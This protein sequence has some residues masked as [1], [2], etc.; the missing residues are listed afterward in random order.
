MIKYFFSLLL[1]L[2]FG[3]V[4][5]QFEKVLM[6]ENA[7]KPWVLWYWVKAAVSKEGIT[8]D[9]EAMKRNGIGGAFLVAVRDTTAGIPKD[10]QVRQLT[11]EFWAMVKFSMSEAKRIGLQMG[12][13]FSDG[14]ALGGGPW[15]TP[16]MSMQKVV[17]A[18]TV[19]AGNKKLN[20]KIPQT[21]T[22]KGYS[23]RIAV[24]AFPTPNGYTQSTYS[25]NPVITTESGENAD[26]LVHK[27]T[28]ESFKSNKPT[29]IQY[30]FKEPFLCRSISIA[31]NGNNYQAQK[32]LVQKSD[33]GV[34]FT[35]VE[36]LE[37]PRA[38][39]QD[40]DADF[41]YSIVPTT[42]KYFRFVFNREG[43]EPGSEDLDNAK[44]RPNLKI[45]N[46]TLSS[47]ARIDQYEGKA[48]YVWRQSPRTPNEKISN[49]WC[50]DP[51][52]MIDITKY[53][54]SNG[55]LS[56]NA[57]SGNWTIMHFAHTS[58]GHT[59]ATGGGGIGL[60]S[61]KFNADAVKMQYEH[62]YGEAVKQMG[63]ELAHD[64]L[65]FFYIDSW[66]CGSQNWS[67]QFR[68]EFIK[69]RQYDP[70]KYLP[71]MAGI[72]VKSI[73]ESERYLYDIRQTITELV[74]DKFFVTL[75]NIAH[76]NGYVFTAE[77][78]AP[79]MLGDGMLHYSKVDVPMSEFWYNS[80]THDKP[81]DIADAINAAHVYGKPIVQAEAF[82]TVRMLWNEH[83]GILK[84]VQDRNYAF[85]INRLVYHVFTHNPWVNKKPG[86]TLDGVGLLFQRD[87]TWWDNGGK[88]WVDYATNSQRW[89][90][91]GR[92][93]ADIAV[94]TGDDL[95][96]RSILPD[97]LVTTF[98][99]LMGKEKVVRE[100]TRLENKDQPMAEI[101]VGVFNAANSPLPHQWNDIL[102]GYQYDC[103]NPDALINLAKVENGEIVLPGGARYKILV[104][105][106][107]SQLLSNN[108][109]LDPKSALKIWDLINA[110]AKVVINTPWTA[111]TGLGNFK[112]DDIIVKNI[113]NKLSEGI[114]T[115]VADG[116]GNSVFVKNIG[117]GLVIKGAIEI[118]NLDVLGITRDIVITD[119]NIAANTDNEITYT[120]KSA[121]GTDIYFI[122]NQ[123]DKTKSATVSLRASNKY[124][125]LYD[126]VSNQYSNLPVT[127]KDN[128]T[129]ADIWLA[130]YQ[131]L[132]IIL[133]DTEMLTIKENIKLV[134]KTPVNGKWQVR[135]DKD[136]G[137][138]EK[139]VTSKQLTTWNMNTDSSIAYYSGT[140]S[141]T[142]TANFKKKANQ[143][144]VLN[145]SEIYNTATVRIN[146][147]DCGTLWTY[148][149]SLDVTK[150]IKSGKN[151]IEILVTNTWHNRLI[152][153]ENLPK[154]KRVTTTFAPFRLANRPLENAG[155]AGSVWLESF[156]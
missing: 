60:E 88:A 81:N 146:G 120:H 124:I 107:K 3:T 83:P 118:S 12:F 63:P 58:T 21:E 5:A 74:N 130:P 142:T 35:N 77:S 30:S 105:P 153:D 65:K 138:P 41:T 111:S 147:I 53:V 104:L 155:L 94:F 75:R 72:P 91:K 56:W 25:I 87:Q 132:F 86:M 97:R 98:P 39:W 37:A 80:P 152:G 109:L 71:A 108:H 29:W 113:Y 92:P 9:L 43:T 76:S 110:G 93:V 42:A 135:F 51:A 49:E 151:K 85:G 23:K 139:T 129:Q 100:R 82:T 117:S 22:Y 154:E 27:T 131:A 64:V 156:E 95:P 128:R 114:F 141:Y 133:T 78:V 106:A 54:N 7:E 33:D 69:R 46:L 102:N 116:N 143:K 36:Q 28:K 136:L 6:P 103:I 59:N 62:W 31:T 148:P 101:P 18:D 145:F 38:G 20:F 84:H 8:A 34:R 137:G 73:D 45:V 150:A 149:Y 99:G 123:V 70:L 26:F 1:L 79:T 89:L 121:D 112:E 55:E 134:A 13:H 17:F 16:E 14:F 90:Q 115:K 67:S 4:N 66:E 19:V 127:V 32:L 68:E 15:I 57:P 47:A 119:K 44:W 52:K 11:P 48:G 2:N 125:Y 122:S 144:L 24:L 40:T 140:A 61:D 126:A 10:K 50:I 96:R